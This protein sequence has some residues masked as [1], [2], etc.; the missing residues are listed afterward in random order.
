[1]A[2]LVVCY[3]T[4]S[5]R[6]TLQPA[7]WQIESCLLILSFLSPWHSKLHSNTN[8]YISLWALPSFMITLV[9]FSELLT[10][11]LLSVLTLNT[12][13]HSLGVHVMSANSKLLVVQ[14][15]KI[16][17]SVPLLCALHEFIFVDKIFHSIT[18]EHV[19]KCSVKNARPRIQSFRSLGSRK[20]CE[21]ATLVTT[22]S[23]SI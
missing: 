4:G 22:R 6:C 8:L 20:K 14:F 15:V 7:L 11:T 16:F 1:M 12:H 13:S 23:T 21:S 19:V 2:F 9:H 10:N 3:H 18:A 5:S 17:V